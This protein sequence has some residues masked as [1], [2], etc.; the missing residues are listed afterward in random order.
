MKRNIMIAAS[1]PMI[2]TSGGNPRVNK[3]FVNNLFLRKYVSILGELLKVKGNLNDIKIVYIGGYAKEE[4]IS[5]AKLYISAYNYYLNS[6]GYEPLNKSNLT[7]VDIDN[8]SDA[9]SSLEQCDLLFLG[10]GADRKFA[11]TIYALEEKGMKLNELISNKNI[12]VSSICSGSVMSAERIYGGVY[13]SYYYGKE[14]FNYPLNLPSLSINPVTMET[15]FCPNDAT[16]QKNIEFI[17]NHLKPDSKKCLFFACKPNSFFLIEEGKIISMGEIYLFV[18]GLCLEI[19]KEVEEADVTLLVELVNTY[20]K[21]KNKNAITSEILLGKIKNA[22][23]SLK[24]K[25]IKPELQLE[26]E[27]IVHLFSKKEVMKDEKNNKQTDKWKETLKAKLDY[28]FSDENLEKFAADLE[29]QER[30]QKLDRSIVESYNVDSSKNY[31]EE[32]YLKMNIISLIKKSLFQYHGY[33]SDFKKDLF[34]LINEYISLN[35]R[36]VFYILDTC[37]CL[38][39]NQN[40]K[41]ILNA[42]K[43]SN[44]RRAQQIINTTERQLKLFRKEMN[45]ERS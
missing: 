30:Y 44:L 28:L 3:D 36:L 32:L 15:D 23:A 35:D 10:I 11:S 14:P 25:E 41:Q 13:D 7:V 1:Y 8:I 31:L 4:N 38:F 43:M 5:R 17:E 2:I 33:L 18:D 20:N 9:L 42:I 39:S 6:L 37:G 24:K 40:I 29:F 16:V 27:S 19:T 26:E 21:L 45:Y 12:L 22:I 34:T